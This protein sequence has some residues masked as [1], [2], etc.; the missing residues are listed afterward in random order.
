MFKL[1]GHERRCGKELTGPVPSWSNVVKA[2]LGIRSAVVRNPLLLGL[3]RFGPRKNH[4]KNQN[5]YS[6]KCK[7]DMEKI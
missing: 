3:L 7:Q 4:M 2:K 5:K 1:R 6:T